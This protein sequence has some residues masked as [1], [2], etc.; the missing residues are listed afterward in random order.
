MHEAPHDVHGFQAAKS[1]IVLRAASDGYVVDVRRIGNEDYVQV[2]SGVVALRLRRDLAR[3]LGLRLP[4]ELDADCREISGSC[5][6]KLR[7]K[8]GVVMDQSPLTIF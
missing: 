8:I 3:E 6:F 4:L 5:P 2:L 1:R 7:G